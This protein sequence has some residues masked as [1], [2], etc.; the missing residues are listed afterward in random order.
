[1][2]F[3]S[4]KEA[5]VRGTVLNPQIKQV[6]FVD[7]IHPQ[8]CGDSLR[9]LKYISYGYY[10]CEFIKYPFKINACKG[11][12]LK[13]QVDNPQ[14]EQVEFIDKEWLQN[15]GDILRII[16]KI[17]GTS[18]YEIEFVKYPCRL[19][20]AKGKIKEGSVDNPH[21]PYK[22]KYT[23]LN[24]IKKYKEKPTVKELAMGL[25]LSLSYT[26][27]KINEFQLKTYIDYFESF[28]EKSIRNEISLLL[29]KKL[30][31]YQDNKY[32]IDIYLSEYLLGIE[33]NG[34]YWHSELYKST[35]YHQEKSL[36]FEGKNFSL[37]HIFEYEWQNKQEIIKSI[38]KN[39]LNVFKH[40]IGA[41]QCKIKELDYKRYANFCNENHLQGE[42][43]AKVKLGL[44][45]KEEL[46][47]TISFSIPRFTDKYEWEIIRECSKM[48]WCVIGGKEKLW[49]H[50]LKKYNP[51]SVI[52]YCDYSKFKGESYLKLGFEKVRLNKPGFVWWDSGTNQIYW[53]NPYKHQEYKEKYIKIYD[54][55]QL[56]F[57]W[58]KK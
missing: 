53:R 48:G 46:V 26:N 56:V 45:Y 6:E 30:F 38:I 51:E 8:N 17:K 3:F 47:Q 22:H 50:F 15:C 37:I 12:I 31:S 36:Y 55:G 33:Y 13:G 39:K 32:E 43:G 25:N 52:S 44:F 57:T 14:I 20:I 19:F 10:E 49:K 28:E 1:M 54:C 21:L 40:K 2:K 4:L 11:N 16:K 9:V 5:I 23:L 42:A 24:I 41:R 58:F 7:K 29:D 27:I 35:N 34:N 18:L